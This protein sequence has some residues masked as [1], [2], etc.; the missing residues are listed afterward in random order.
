MSFT[1]TASGDSSHG[2]WRIGTIGRS[3]FSASDSSFGTYSEVTE[4][5]ESTTSTALLAESASPIADSHA[6]PPGM[7]S[8]S[9]H[10][11]TPRASSAVTR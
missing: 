11:F 5:G 3:Y 6:A 4:A 8:R 7:S 10:T 2:S 9:T 1:A